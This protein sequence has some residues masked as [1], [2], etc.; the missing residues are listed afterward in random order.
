MFCG[1]TL[2]PVAGRQRDV[3]VWKIRQDCFEAQQQSQDFCTYLRVHALRLFWR[4][5]PLIFSTWG[6]V[7]IFRLPFVMSTTHGLPVIY[8]LVI[9]KIRGSISQRTAP[10]S[11]VELLF[12]IVSLSLA[13]LFFCCTVAD[14]RF[15]ACSP[16]PSGFACR[17][18]AGISSLYGPRGPQQP[19]V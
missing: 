3:A 17:E 11:L 14:R 7:P 16:S 18:Y 12:S 2:V 13:C 9:C 15:W 5:N 1:A 8:Y 6:H 19:G 10:Q 4:E